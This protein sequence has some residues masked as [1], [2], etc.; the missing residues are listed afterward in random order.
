[1]LEPGALTPTL[2]PFRSLGDLYCRRLCA[3][4]PTVICGGARA[5]KRLEVLLA[6]LH[7]DRVLVGARHHVGAAA[8]HGAQGERVPPAKSLMRTLSP[9]S[10][11]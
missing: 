8:D 6:R 7:V 4:M 9:S 1:M 11:K 5:H 2:S 10:L 3:E